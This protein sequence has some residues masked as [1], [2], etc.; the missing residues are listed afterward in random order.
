MKGI[1]VFATMMFLGLAL[2][3]FSQYRVMDIVQQRNASVHG[4]ANLPKDEVPSLGIADPEITPYMMGSF[5]GL[6]FF[7]IGAIGGVIVVVKNFTRRF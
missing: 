6:G 1:Y 5:A 7:V 3:F 2:M 4:S